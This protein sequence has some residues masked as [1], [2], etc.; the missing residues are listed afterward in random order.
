MQPRQMTPLRPF[1]AS[2]QVLSSLLKAGKKTCSRLRKA[3]IRVRK[4]WHLDETA[5][6]PGFTVR[7]QKEMH[8]SN[9]LAFSFYSVWNLSPWNNT[10]H[11]HFLVKPF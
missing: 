3:H 1:V 11:I 9:Q 7:K 2:T 6:H 8:A 5:D 4:T 10:T